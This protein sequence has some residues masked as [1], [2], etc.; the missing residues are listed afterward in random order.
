MTIKKIAVL[1][2]G[3][4]GCAAAADL[5]LRGFEVRLFSRSESTVAKIAKRGEIEL[6]EGGAR[7]K[8][9][10]YFLS[11]HVP[12]VVQGV[13]LIVIA[14]PAVGHEYLANN[15]AKYLADGQRILLN[16][17]HTG[18]SL[19][20]ANL[21]RQLG[22]KA[23]VQI[24][25]T[26]TLTYICRMPQPGTVEVYRRTT[27][28]HCAAFPGKHT[29]E[30]LPQIQTVF[31][32]VVA[33]KNVL[34]TGF[35]NINAIMHPAGMLGNAG[36]IEKSGGNFL[37]YYEGIT[38][39]IGR[40]ID[41][42]DGERV[43]M[44]RALG[45]EPLRF[46]DIFHRAGLTSDAGRASGSAHQAIH[47]SEPNKTIKSPPSLD[48]RYIREDIGYGLVPMAEIGRLLGV[49]TPVMDALITLA[50]TAL[51]VDFRAEGLTLEKMGLAGTRADQLQSI[52][53]NGFS[54]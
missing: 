44:V 30:L 20:F 27:N 31:P 4:G 33:A 38:P 23:D 13:D 39:S 45:L 36:W 2:A 35:S 1:G 16:P 25:E 43:A 24:C 46:V 49:K 15:L 17:G 42:V 10:P 5:T 21:L 18:G 8:A 48:H 3:N 34:E 19:H 22:C 51:G 28:L 37:W 26:V 29:A 40:W 11:P 32:N 41:A 7:K 47:D 52:L 14:T 9:A 12:P 54:T 53:D 6:I 50:S